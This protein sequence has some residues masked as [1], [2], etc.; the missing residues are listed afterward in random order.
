MPCLVDAGAQLV[1]KVC[2]DTYDSRRHLLDHVHVSPTAKYHVACC[3]ADSGS[4]VGQRAF[5]GQCPGKMN[6]FDAESFCEGHSMH[7]CSPW[8]M[9]AACNTGC[10]MDQEYVW[11]APPQYLVASYGS[12]CAGGSW[13]EAGEEDRWADPLEKHE[14]TCCNMDGTHAERDSEALGGACPG[15]MNY[16]QAVARCED[17]GMRLCSLAEL[18]LG[19]KTGCSMDGK[20]QWTAHIGPGVLTS[21]FYDA[22]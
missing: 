6:F 1:V 18:P 3:S 11:A 2:P 7:L 15:P 19:C 12:S 4:L 16:Y 8:E 21:D 20:L 13:A 9:S 17:A 22:Q 10:Q 14:V 5:G